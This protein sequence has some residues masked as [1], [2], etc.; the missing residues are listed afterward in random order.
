MR[1][2]EIP[3]P[4][5]G[6]R[7]LGIPTVIDRLIQQSISQRLTAIWEPEFHSWSLALDPIVR[8]SSSN[9]ST[10]VSGRGLHKSCGARLR[11][12]LRQGES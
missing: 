9:T 4:G 8:P 11:E 2:V 5:G 6:K 10:K 1:R 12:I 3:K 7:L